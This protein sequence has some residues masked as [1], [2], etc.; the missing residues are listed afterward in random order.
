MP[1]PSDDAGNGGEFNFPALPTPPRQRPHPP[2][3]EV[4]V[5]EEERLFFGFNL[6]VT[7]TLLRSINGIPGNSGNA[8]LDALNCR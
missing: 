8:R 1:G 3:A 2:L 5:A 4:Q 6:Y 7:V